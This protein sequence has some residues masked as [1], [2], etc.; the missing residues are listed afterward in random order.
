VWG[1]VRGDVLF[2]DW[3]T[4]DGAYPT[5]ASI[6]TK[7]IPGDILLTQHTNDRKDVSWVTFMY[8][9]VHEH[10]GKVWVFHIY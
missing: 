9:K 8:A 7:R 5:H 2:I 10:G 4:S 6:V 1:V 3:K